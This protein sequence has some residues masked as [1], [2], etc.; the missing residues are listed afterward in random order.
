MALA[1]YT[2]ILLYNAEKPLKLSIPLQKW[3]NVIHYIRDILIVI[4]WIQLVT[5]AIAFWVSWYINQYV[6]QLNSY[7][8]HGGLLGVHLILVFMTTYYLSFWSVL[9]SVFY[10][11]FYYFFLVWLFLQSGHWLYPSLDPVQNPLWYLIVGLM[12]FAQ[13]IGFGVIHLITWFK[14]RFFLKLQEQ[15]NLEMIQIKLQYA[16]TWKDYLRLEVAISCGL[17]AFLSIYAVVV[18]IGCAFQFIP[19]SWAWIVIFSEI[20]Y[21][22]GEITVLSFHGIYLYL[23]THLTNTSDALD[24][25]EKRYSFLSQLNGGMLCVFEAHF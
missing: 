22:L 19:L 13:L 10:T 17:L 21:F 11:I 1:T 15:S 6:L 3:M 12:P 14:N 24:D 25:A 8:S 7:L 2:Q 23:E 9:I 4:L 20:A 16:V 18:I 5:T